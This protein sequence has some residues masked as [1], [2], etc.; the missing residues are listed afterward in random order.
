MN[1]LYQL[2]SIAKLKNTHPHFIM[3]SVADLCSLNDCNQLDA[4]PAS[5]KHVYISQVYSSILYSAIEAWH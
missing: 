1:S 4:N 5:A 2:Q 3:T